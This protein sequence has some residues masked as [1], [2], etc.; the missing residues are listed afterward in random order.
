[1][2]GRIHIQSGLAGV[3]IDPNRFPRVDS[4]YETPGYETA[5]NKAEIYVET[6]VASITIR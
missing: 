1:V 3:S 4:G 2:A 6:G 5:A